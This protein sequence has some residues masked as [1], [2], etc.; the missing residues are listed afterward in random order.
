MRRATSKWLT[1]RGRSFSW[2]V[3]CIA[4]RAYRVDLLVLAAVD[5]AVVAGLLEE[6]GHVDG[7]VVDVE[8][9]GPLVPLEDLVR[10]VRVGGEH[11][12]GELH[13]GPTGGGAVEAVGGDGAPVG[14]AEACEGQLDLAAAKEA[15]LLPSGVV[16]GGH[17]RQAVGPCTAGFLG[18]G[19]Q[20][21]HVV[22]GLGDEGAGFGEQGNVEDPAQDAVVRNILAV[23][24]G[25]LPQGGEGGGEAGG[26]PLLDQQEE[27]LGEAGVVFIPRGCM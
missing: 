5:G 19:V 26:E 25:S 24:L 2:R 10:E 3:S 8:G 13:A 15:H 11:V 17:V 16:H 12:E 27:G 14:Q 23:P 20:H 1:S 18:V 21:V 9:P 4:G 6:G 22:A 7:D